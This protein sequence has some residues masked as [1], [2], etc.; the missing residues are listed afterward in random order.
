MRHCGECQ[1]CC[2]LLPVPPLGKKAGER[3][4]YQKFGK[5]CAV[6]RG[7]AMPPECRLWSCRWLVNDDTADLPRP[8]HAHY[9][10]DMMPDFI[11]IRENATGEKQH[12]QVV[13]IWCDPKHPDAHRDPHL[14]AYLRRRGAEGIAALVRFGSAHG[15]TLIPPEMSADGKW[16]EVTAMEREKPHSLMDMLVALGERA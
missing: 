12:V 4:R 13:Q 9:V 3:C 2:K 7:A 10:I 15:I 11:T 16:H 14:R 1:L 5:G 6:Y 8:D